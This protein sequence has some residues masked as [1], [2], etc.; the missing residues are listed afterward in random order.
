[1]IFDRL[2]KLLAE[3][4]VVDEDTITLETSF[5]DD[6]GADSLD[7]VEIVMAIEE[8]FD[9]PEVAEDELPKLLTVGDVVNYISN[10]VY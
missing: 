5:V 10:A 2:K 3:Q 6:L 7:I 1:M 8:E 4:F 9:I